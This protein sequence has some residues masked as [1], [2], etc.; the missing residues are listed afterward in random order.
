MLGLI[1]D[2]SHADRL[3]ALG[4]QPIVADALDRNNLVEAVERFAADAVIN[5]LTALR[6][7]SAP[8]QRNGGY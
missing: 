6:R 7:G 8:P 5:E 2:R 4:V 3:A 1:R